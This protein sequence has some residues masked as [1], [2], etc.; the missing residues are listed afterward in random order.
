M[1]GGG[2]P[3]R[4]AKTLYNHPVSSAIGYFI[5]NLG[6]SSEV[7]GK[8]S[9]GHLEHKLK[10]KVEG[11]GEAIKNRAVSEPI[12]IGWACGAF[13]ATHYEPAGGPYPES[14]SN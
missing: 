8:E 6:D 5:V 1:S 11:N 4:W 12:D 9:S 13:K 7:N 14:R 2:G 3:E 10:M